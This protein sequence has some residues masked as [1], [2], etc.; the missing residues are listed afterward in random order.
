MLKFSKA[1]MTAIGAPQPARFVERMRPLLR[2]RYPEQTAEIPEDDL[3]SIIEHGMQSARRY[4]IKT[5]AGAE[6]YID[7][8]FLIAFDFDESVPFARD[9]LRR[10][11]FTG[12]IRID[13]LCAMAEGRVPESPEDG[14]FFP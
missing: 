12:K 5:T 1:Q 7:L 3:I 2:E 14:P 13:L 9:V 11:D 10:P 8:M 6:R 4:E